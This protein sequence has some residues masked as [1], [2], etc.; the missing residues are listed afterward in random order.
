[1]YRVLA[2]NSSEIYV[3]ALRR[4][5]EKQ[6]QLKITTDGYSTLAAIGHFRPDILL[7]D[8]SLIRKDAL[9][10]LRQSVFIPQTIL[11]TSNYMD[12]RVLSQLQVLGVRQLM[13]MP[14]ISMVEMTL[15]GIMEEMDNGTCMGSLEYLTALQLHALG[16]QVHLDGYRQLCIGIPMLCRDPEQTVTKTLYPAIAEALALPDARTV[17]HSIRKAIF[18]AWQSRDNDLWNSLF[19]NTRECPSNK[20]FLFRLSERISELSGF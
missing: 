8:A 17:E 9:S 11:V 16:F 13:L 15:R 4:Q 14:P 7:L 5:L 2:A 19:P 20:K 1:M 18:Q 6:C 3:S 12:S 10:V